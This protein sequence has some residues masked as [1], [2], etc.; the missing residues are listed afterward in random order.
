MVNKIRNT[1]QEGLDLGL[2]LGEMKFACPL[3]G[4]CLYETESEDRLNLR[5]NFCHH[6]RDYL[7]CEAYIG[8]VKTGGIP[9]IS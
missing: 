3:L 4:N 5:R 6:S 1:V 8:P 7:T 9:N 2:E